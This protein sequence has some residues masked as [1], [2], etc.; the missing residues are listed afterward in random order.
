MD[1]DGRYSRLDPSHKTA[2]FSPTFDN[3]KI[4]GAGEE[5]EVGYV[6]IVSLPVDS[7][8]TI[9]KVLKRPNRE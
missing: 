3:Y 5:N 7:K 6:D 1:R 4:Y 8:D 2:W 9:M